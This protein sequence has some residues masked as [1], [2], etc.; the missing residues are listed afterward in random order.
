MS[1]D[2]HLTDRIPAS[3]TSEQKMMGGLCF[4]VNDK[5]WVASSSIT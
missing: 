1:Y 5:M 4:T 2:E 3:L